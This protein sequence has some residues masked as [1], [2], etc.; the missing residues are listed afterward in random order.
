MLRSLH[1]RPVHRLSI[2]LLLTLVWVFPTAA[3]AQSTGSSTDPVRLALRRPFA[4]K[5]KV[6]P[7]SRTEL[8]E[9]IRSEAEDPATCFVEP[10]PLPAQEPPPTA[11]AEIEIEAL[12]REV[13]DG[14]E[15]HEREYIEAAN[16]EMSNEA[17]EELAYFGSA[18]HLMHPSSDFYSDPLKSLVTPPLHLDKVDPRDF[19]I[20]IIINQRVEAWMV[21]FLTRGRRYYTRWL[22]RG[23][24]YI[25]LLRGRLEEAGLP[26]DLVYQAMIESGFNPYATSRASAVG[27]WQF[28]SYTGRAYDLEIDWWVDER[29]NPELATTAAIDYLSYLYRLFGDWTLAS[30]A[31]NAGEGK[32]GRAIKRYGTRDIWELSAHKNTYLKPETKN[33]VPKIMAAAILSKY[34]DRYG[35]PADILD[36][37]RLPLWDYDKVQVP[38]ATGLAVVAK[39]LEIDEEELEAM[40]P[41]LRRWCTPPG[42]EN[43]P[44]N[45]PLGTAEKVL[46]ELKKIPEKDRVTFVRHKVRRGDTIGAIARRF[47][48]PGKALMKMNGI[49]D[50]RRLKVGRHLVVP[51]R[52]NGEGAKNRTLVHVVGK[53]ESLSVIAQRYGTTVPGLKERNGL[54]SNVLSIGQRLTVTGTAGGARSKKALSAVAT[55][56]RETWYTVRSGDNLGAIAGEHGTSV[57]ALKKL[58]GLKGDRIRVGQR[59]KVRVAKAAKTPK[60]RR[61]VTYTVVAGDVVGTIA[62]R[63]SMSRGD[64]R[65]LNKLKKDRIYVGQKLRV[66]G[67]RG[68]TAPKRTA[69]SSVKRTY[70]VK[71]GDSLSV[72]ASRHGVS[73]SDIKRWNRLKSDRIKVGKKLT[74]RG[75][76]APGPTTRTASVKTSKYKVRS[77]DSLWE[78]ARRFGVTVASL[79]ST[80]GLRSSSLK[81]GQILRIRR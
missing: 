73:T 80:N 23:E 56:T 37:D 17:F 61:S 60:K 77:G 7:D 40:N 54:R 32:I 46:A 14:F 75:G 12:L 38:E 71:S 35:L 33:Y 15:A 41:E 57:S 72:I 13:L 29:R 70:T 47:G 48:V 69:K 28:M 16:V 9:R 43:Y 21:Y 5:K 68:S 51:V 76:K 74:I 62:K 64:L 78:I 79:K 8:L 24:R 25:P 26:Q 27:V 30:A 2:A 65:T 59:L 53:G 11:F 58:N 81:V 67:P 66:Y 36:E 39:I 45:V 50:A 10:S 4:K 20:P 22:A 55:A 18:D 31:Y 19:D 3:A 1:S 49:R 44:L 42:I 52:P 63:F 6:V 34:R